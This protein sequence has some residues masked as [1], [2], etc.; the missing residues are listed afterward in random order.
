MV[1]KACFARCPRSPLLICNENSISS[2][3]AATTHSEVATEQ[4][5]R[6][7]Q[8]SVF[9]GNGAKRSIKV[10]QA[11]YIGLYH[12]SIP[13]GMS[14]DFAHDSW[15]TPTTMIKESD[16]LYHKHCQSLCLT[17]SDLHESDL[18]TCFWVLIN[19]G[20]GFA[21]QPMVGLHGGFGINLIRL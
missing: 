19:M 8:A 18:S 1:L 11:W 16:C 21:A 17:R 7:M 6:R 4:N 12:S 2:Y 15:G 5:R 3:L 13:K 20:I 9:R 14:I 10:L